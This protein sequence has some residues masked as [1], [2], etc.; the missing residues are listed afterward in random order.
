MKHFQHAAFLVIA[1]LLLLFLAIFPVLTLDAVGKLFS[2]F[3]ALDPGNF[4][5]LLYLEL[6]RAFTTVVAILAALW[7]VARSSRAAD[8]RAIALFLMF[9][10]LTYE[11]IFGT[12]GYPGPFQE[13]LT[14]ALLG[15]GVS[16]EF[17]LWLFGPVP[18]SLWLVL[19]A[20][21]RFSVVF[22][23]PPLS[24]AAID[25]SGKTD[26][27]GALRGAGVAGLDV[28][29]GFRSV[30]KKLLEMGALRPLPLWSTAVLLVVITTLLDRGA[31]VALFAIAASL[32]TALAI[33]NLRASYNVIDEAERKRM[34]WLML[35]FALGGSLFLISALPLLFFDDPF[36][37]IPALVLLM[38]A[39]TVIMVCLAMGVMYRGPADAGEM[40]ERVPGGA[41]LALVVLLM[42][43]LTFTTVSL[44][45]ERTGA[46]RALAFLAALVVTALLYEPLRRGTDR[47]MDR[48]LERTPRETLS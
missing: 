33:T 31:R 25:E 22:P 46:S 42:F 40:L 35:G 41:A 8:G 18:W 29:A 32:V 12:T 19:A 3:A 10:A 14:L 43:A 4:V 39:P 44:I 26:R 15:A 47:A 17:L 34:R 28:G 16:R 5:L 45:T 7:L 2:K 24:A 27:R 48:I 21:L 9:S 23:H 1:A 38:V 13:K 36:A 6:S 20:A 30:A 11:K 37:S